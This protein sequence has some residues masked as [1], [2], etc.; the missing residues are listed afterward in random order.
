MKPAGRLTPIAMLAAAMPACSCSRQT[1]P[2][3]PS[4]VYP[5]A[6]DL[7]RVGKYPAL[8]KSGGG[9]VYD[10]VLEYRVWIHPDGDDYY[11]AFA[12]YDE[13]EQL[14]ERTERAEPPLVLVL[15]R[16]HINE[17]ERGEYVHVKGDRI[18]EWQV[19]WLAGR[20]RGP[21]TIS[22]FLRRRGKESAQQDASSGPDKLRR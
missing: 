12:T 1:P 22:E 2:R 21:D 20:K 3:P 18:T 6:V 14:A 10:E 4:S 7:D 19:E 11:R 13:A 5:V 15:Q 17:P 16:E 9:Y 8:T